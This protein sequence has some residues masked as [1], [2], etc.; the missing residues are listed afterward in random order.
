MLLPDDVR[1][2][3]ETWTDLTIVGAEFLGFLPFESLPFRGSRLG[4]E[5]AVSYLPSLPVGVALAARPLPAAFERDLLLLGAARPAPAVLAR[6]PDLVPLPFTDADLAALAAPYRSVVPGGRDASGRVEV[7]GDGR[8]TP[9]RLASL[10]PDSSR[11]LHVVAHGVYASD[12]ERPAGLAL[13]PA[14]GGGDG[15]VFGEAVE[16]ASAPPLVVLS[17][18]GAAR[19][20]G[21]L[22]DDGVSHLGGAF[23]RAGARAVVLSR[24]DVDLDSSLALGAAFHEAV[25]QG[26]SPARALLFARRRVAEDTERADPFFHSLVHVVGLGH[27]RRFPGDWRPPDGFDAHEPADGGEIPARGAASSGARIALVAAALVAGGLALGAWSR[28]RRRRPS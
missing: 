11:I 24:A 10:T 5:L 23:L 14:P 6:W 18:C 3:L 1:A 13:A 17:S 26:A 27:E 21:R 8:A 12:R 9:S 22:G 2:L 7:L 28:S 20:P 15:L 16:A 4:L 19:G 25:A